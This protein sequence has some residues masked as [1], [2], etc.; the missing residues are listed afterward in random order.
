MSDFVS[1]GRILIIPRGD[2]DNQEEYKMLDLVRHGRTI[3][4]AKKTSTNIEPGTD[5]NEEYWFKFYEPSGDLDD[6]AN[7]RGISF[8][9]EDGVP[10]MEYTV[11]ARQIVYENGVPI[12]MANEADMNAALAN[13]Y[14]GNT[15]NDAPPEATMD[16]ILAEIFNS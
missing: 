13:I 2:W 4:L 14:D 10:Y 3:Y 12:E 5:N 8:L 9:I 7:G 6:K 15:A 16:A 11:S 1:A